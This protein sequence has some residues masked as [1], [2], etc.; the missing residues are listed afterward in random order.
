[1]SDFAQAQYIIDE[2]LAGVR[3]MA[4]DNNGVPPQNMASMSVRIG[5]SKVKLNFV[6]P[7]NTVIDGQLVCTT[8]GVVVVRKEGSMPESVTDG[9][10]ILINENLGA[11]KD[12]PFEDSGLVNEHEYYYRFFSY[13]DHGVF[14]LNTANVI[15]ATPKEYVLY[16]FRINKSDSNPATRIE[17][18]EQAVGMT[19]AKMNYDT[20]EF[21]YGSWNPDEI[22]F[23]QN[24]YP[25][26]VKSDGTED[27]KLDPDDYTKKK[28]GS[29]SDVS[30][31]SYDGNAMARFDTVWLYQY[32][33]ASYEYCYIC[34]IQL[35]EN[36]HAYAHQREDGSIMEYIWLSCFEGALVSSKV[37]SIK[38]LT[39][40]YSQTGA[41]E[42][43]YASNNGN[44][45]YTRTWAQRN[46]VNM[47]LTLMAR[48]DDSQTSYGYGYY[49]GG[50]SSS[51]NYLQTGFGS[52]K[53][54]FYG[55]KANR[56]VVKVFHIENWWGSIWERI[57]GLMYVS[58]KIYTKM[59]KPYNTTG[60]GYT[61]TGVTM[62][63]TSGGY[64]SVTKM[65]ENG[66][67][68]VTMSGSQT[69]YTCDG[70]WFNASQVDYAI[71]G[72]GCYDGVLCGASCV[73]LNNLVSYAAWSI[74]AAL[75][76]EQP[77]AA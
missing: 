59:V 13:S 60:T 51:P 67:L 74:G 28:D 64:C 20:G 62:G 61:N 8:K 11:Y 40:M 36:Y 31:T 3:D 9:E 76:C 41:N 7:E 25:A 21:E 69:T 2:V 45:W 47:L 37:R 50:S 43:T 6:E 1:M 58:G 34:N 15:K 18:L 44:L 75:S 22:F 57:A 77:L 4:T 30:N 39:P 35:N 29:A 68:P 55:S 52:A 5:D 32:E 48:S 26:M 24:N 71:V 14:N 53:G 72:G 38:G 56:D 17:Y 65:T 12:T 16:G 63:G 23:L 54:R 19:P 49:T 33:D 42:I 73:Y 46:L 10:V 27:Y 66:R 70:G